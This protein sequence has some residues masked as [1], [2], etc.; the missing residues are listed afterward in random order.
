MAAK[1]RR[2]PRK[3]GSARKGRPAGARPSSGKAGR[4]PK[5]GGS[6]RGA[7]RFPKKAGTRILEDGGEPAGGLWA[8]I[9]AESA[10]GKKASRGLVR[11]NAHLARCGVASRR[12]ADGL[13]A[14]GRVQ[15]DGKVVR[16]LGTRI[17]PLRAEVRVDGERLRPE[18]PVYVLLHKPKGVVCTNA[19]NER[20][21]RAIDLCATV[22]GR[23]FPVGRLDADSEGLLLMTNDGAF[24]ARM[25]H[26]RYGVPKIY[27]LVLRGR[28]DEADLRKARGGVWLAEGRTQGLGIRVRRRG[29][30]RSY[31]EVSVREGR[32]RE[33]RRIF[34]RVGHPVLRLR[35]I[36]IG[37]LSIRGVGRGRWRFLKPAEVRALL[38][39]ASAGD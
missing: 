5:Q 22:K 25:T 26:P 3:E 35:R 12:G 9:L 31:L 7:P 15:V 16:E 24:A 29:R 38:E 30:E 19:P 32:N 6:K 14:E 39:A 2:K 37:S 27:S 36:R 1:K 8:K 10:R 20:K 21:P 13:I 34:A 18:K 28:I 17:D 33:L 11:L 23:I 4:R